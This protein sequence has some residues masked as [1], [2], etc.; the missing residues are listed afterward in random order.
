[1]KNFIKENWALFGFIFALLI[2][3]N[4]GLIASVF[5]NPAI[6]NLVKG[7]GA[8]LLAYYWNPTQ[9]ASANKIGG[10]AVIPNKGF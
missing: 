5:S 3:D 10:G 4:T 9:K 2:D 7:L 6:Q 1:M 8:I